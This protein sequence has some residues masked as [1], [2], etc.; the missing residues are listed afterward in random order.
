MAPATFDYVAVGG[1]VSQRNCPP[2]DGVVTLPDL[3]QLAGLPALQPEITAEKI[4]DKL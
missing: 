2:H 3:D 1:V 4:G